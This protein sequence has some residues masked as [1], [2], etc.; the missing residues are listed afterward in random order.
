M[1]PLGP[2]NRTG[3]KL[4]NHLPALIRSCLTSKALP[5]N[6]MHDLWPCRCRLPAAPAASLAQRVRRFL[7]STRLTGSS[8]SQLLLWAWT[9]PTIVCRVCAAACLCVRL[10]GSQFVAMSLILQHEHRSFHVIAILSGSS[11]IIELHAV[12]ANSTQ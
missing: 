1:I 2:W 12:L 11:F 10:H 8:G 3:L 7:P 9:G 5:F 4:A 6:G